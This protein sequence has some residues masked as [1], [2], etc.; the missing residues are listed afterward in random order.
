MNK[1]IKEVNVELLKVG[2][3]DLPT[4]PPNPIS[5]LKEVNGAEDKVTRI[6]VIDYTRSENCRAFVK[7]DIKRYELQYQDDG[8]TLKIFIN[9]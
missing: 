2:K 8:K 7:H 3:Y 1:E 6:E 9:S 4:M 5:P